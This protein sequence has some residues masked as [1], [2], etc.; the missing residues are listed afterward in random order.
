MML[1][2]SGTFHQESWFPNCSNLVAWLMSHQVMLKAGTWWYQ[3]PRC[4]SWWRRTSWPWKAPDQ[5]TWTSMQNEDKQTNYEQRQKRRCMEIHG[6]FEGL[7]FYLFLQTYF[8]IFWICLGFGWCRLVDIPRIEVFASSMWPL[9][10]RRLM[11]IKLVASQSPWDSV[12]IWVFSLLG[13]TC[14]LF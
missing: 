2:H 12:F 10:R 4:V 3:M 13:D 11:G 14:T 7:C 1:L 6:N 9:K 8:W 5:G